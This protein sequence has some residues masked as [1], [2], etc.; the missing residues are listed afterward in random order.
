MAEIA[1]LRDEAERIGFQ[2]ALPALARA[3]A[4]EP[5]GETR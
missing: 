2:V 5:L 4:G 3:L 1:R